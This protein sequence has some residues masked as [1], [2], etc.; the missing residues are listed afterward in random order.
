MR[1]FSYT[2]ALYIFRY[3]VASAVM[4]FMNCCFVESLKFIL[5]SSGFVLY[6][7]VHIYLGSRI[8]CH[9]NPFGDD[10]PFF[11]FPLSS[12]Y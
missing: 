7:T 5:D 1:M 2:V 4:V 6:F 8:M 11:I 12:S 3:T 9:Q 10:F